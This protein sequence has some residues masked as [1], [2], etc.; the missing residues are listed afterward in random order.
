VAKPPLG[1]LD[2]DD[3]GLRTPEIGERI[4]VDVGQTEDR[5]LLRVRFVGNEAGRL[6]YL[7]QRR[8]DGSHSRAHWTRLRV[9]PLS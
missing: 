7:V 2:R 9:T 3:D 6:F 8:G 5:F 1:H 4:L